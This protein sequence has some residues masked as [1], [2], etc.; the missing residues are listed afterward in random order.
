MTG[1]DPAR[2]Q[3]RGPLVGILGGM[4]P[5]AT[6]DFYAELIRRTP[7]TRD[8]DHLRVAIWAD[9]TVPDRVAAVLR[10]TSEPYPALLEGANNLRMLGA[11]L[12]AIPCHTAH[13]FRQRLVDETGLA[14]LD[15]VQETVD[16]LAAREGTG[17]VGL[18]GTRATLHSRLYQERCAAAG[19]RTLT[20]DDAAQ[21]HVDAAIREVKQGRPASGGAE[22][23]VAL[24][25]LTA[26]GASTL[27]LACTELPIALAAIRGD[28]LPFVLDPTDVLAEAVIRECSRVREDVA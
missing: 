28:D 7:A 1:E 21:R 16:V 22:L 18:L 19:I 14:I 5:A 3:Q 10:G 11:T 6:A 12:V 23:G 2:T 27:V 9:P 8:Q 24:R 13:V 26:A 25:H 4:G 15:M 20:P 17:T